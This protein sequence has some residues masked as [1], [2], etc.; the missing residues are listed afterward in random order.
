V[1]KRSK[2]QGDANDKGKVTVEEFLRRS[3]L[4]MPVRDYLEKFIHGEPLPYAD[5]VDPGQYGDTEF[6]VS[7]L[8]DH[9]TTNDEL[10]CAATEYVR[11]FI[12]RLEE[13]SDVHIWSNPEVLR[14]A[15]PTM[16]L[17][18]GGAEGTWMNGDTVDV[19]AVKAALCR[20][21]TRRELSEFY[22]RNGL[23][24]DFPG[25]DVMAGSVDITGEDEGGNARRVAQILAA[26]GTPRA[27]REM[28]ATTLGEF[29]AAAGVTVSHPALADRAYQLAV[30]VLA[31]GTTKGR[32][33]LRRAHKA[34]SDVLASIPLGKGSES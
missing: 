30:E 16:I 7:V 8:A 17:A 2:A 26:P 19:A 1:T 28:L 5:R 31:G 32:R 10:P 22:E 12:Y 15:Y 24:D 20:L 23:K 14:A 27:T 11:E 6:L 18:T 21:C 33:R 34:V 29:V 9:M 25:F 4:P 3:E 13:S